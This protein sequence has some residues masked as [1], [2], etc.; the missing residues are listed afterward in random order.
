MDLERSSD[1]DCSNSD[2]SSQTSGSSEASS[3]AE[4][5]IVDITPYSREP[6]W[7][8]EDIRLSEGDRGEDSEDSDSCGQ[9]NM[10]I[11]PPSSRVGNTDWCLCGEC[12]EMKTRVESV[13]CHEYEETVR[14]IRGTEV[15]CVALLPRFGTVCMD[16]EVLETALTGI[17]DLTK[18]PLDSPAD[19]M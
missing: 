13:C 7:T 11:W 17:F 8:E 9:N 12:C 3:D 18:R 4:P 1:G 15:K 6:E 5:D 14:K 16:R 2:T 19:N 10:D